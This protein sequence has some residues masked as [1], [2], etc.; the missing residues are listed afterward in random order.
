MS[1]K[2]KIKLEG[3]EYTV[4]RKAYAIKKTAQLREFGYPSLT[5]D[6]LEKQIDALLS[7]KNLGD[8]LTVIG[9]F[10]EGE[11]LGKEGE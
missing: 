1:V 10:M 6:E 7:G 8:G 9:M 5:V 3:R 11:V 2:L 4:P